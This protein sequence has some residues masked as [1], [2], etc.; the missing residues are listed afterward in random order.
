MAVQTRRRLLNLLHTF[1]G[2]AHQKP[3]LSTISHYCTIL[4]QNQGLRSSSEFFHG[5]NDA[6][7]QR[8]QGCFHSFRQMSHATGCLYTR[9][10]GCPTSGREDVRLCIPRLLPAMSLNGQ[11]SVRHKSGG[12]KSKSSSTN[13]DE[14]SDLEELDDDDYEAPTNFKKMKIHV[15]SLRVDS[16]VSSALDIARNRV[17]EIFYGSRLKLNGEKLLKK[18]KQMEEGDYVDLIVERS[19]GDDDRL[20]VK[21]VKVVSV[22]PERTSKDRMVVTVKAWKSPFPIEDTSRAEWKE[23]N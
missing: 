10:S 13:S 22:S 5:K 3:V 11:M 21:R 23:D 7:K 16:V 6:W 20:L 12:K 14:E 19:T 2:G 9:W 18:S 1:Y 15:K 8:A 4:H 17:D